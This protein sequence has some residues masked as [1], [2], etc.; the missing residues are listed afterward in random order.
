MRA[1]ERGVVG[2]GVQ[3]CETGLR[4]VRATVGDRAVDLD[5]RS[6]A[7]V[8]STSY[9]RAIAVQSVSSGRRARAWHAAIEAWST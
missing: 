1:R 3:H 6:G 4:T 8:A 2:D 9:H 5:D 7:A